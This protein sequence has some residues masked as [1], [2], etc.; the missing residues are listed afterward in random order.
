M[1]LF[2]YPHLKIPAS[3]SLGVLAALGEVCRAAEESPVASVPSA[4]RWGVILQGHPGDAPHARQFRKVT[5]QLRIWLLE[6]LEFPPAQVVSLPESPAVEAEQAPP[7]TAEQIRTTLAQFAAQLQPDD[8]LWVFTVGHGS[9]DGQRAWFHVAGPDPSDVD[10]ADWLG[11]VKCREQVLWLTHSSS[12]WLVKPLSRPGRIVIAATAAD[13]EPNET[14]FPQALISVIR[15]P[16]PQASPQPDGDRLRPWNV[17]ALY[18]AVVAEVGRRFRSDNRLPT[19]HAQLDDNGDGLG[20]ETLPQATPGDPTA[21][22]PSTDIPATA[23][24]P[25]GTPPRR[26]GELARLVF[27]PD[28]RRAPASDPASDP[29]SSKPSRD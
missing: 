2:P 17:A 23:S 9:H 22:T 28:R 14:E 4:R 20:T 29:S 5:A 15:Q 7:L 26:D 25:K 11:A 10:L 13:D 27:V 19:E 12:G 24:P 1:S 3:L 8:S 18:T 16:P 6:S 21:S